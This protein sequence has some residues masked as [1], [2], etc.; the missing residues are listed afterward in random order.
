NLGYPFSS[1]EPRTNVIFNE[2]EVLRAF[3]PAVAG[4]GDRLKVF[5][6]DEHALTLG[7]RRVIVKTSAGSTATDY[8][9]SPLTANPGTVVNP[10]V[11]TPM[12]DGEQAGT[13]TSV[14]AGFPD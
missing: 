14:C 7:V 13:D 4:R 6:N 3:T 8:P 1:S 12:L 11:G 2:S 9:V 5:Y 10:Q